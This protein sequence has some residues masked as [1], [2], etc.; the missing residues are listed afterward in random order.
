M[1]FKILSTF[2]NLDLIPPFEYHCKY[3]LCA[4]SIK[5]LNQLRKVAM[6]AI[7]CSLLERKDCFSTL[8][9]VRPPL[10]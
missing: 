5:F 1:T 9:V 6:E 2:Q 4:W 3:I 8:Q 10:E 7:L